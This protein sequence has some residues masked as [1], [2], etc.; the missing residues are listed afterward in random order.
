MNKEA[1][2]A[3][4]RA[5]LS[6]LPENET[7]ERIS[8][9]REMIDDRMADGQTEEEA[10]AGIGSMDEI[11]EQITAEIPLSVI[12]RG[13]ASQRKGMKGWEIALLILGAPLWIPLLIAAIAV[14]L[15][16]YAALWAVV[17]SLWAVDLSLAAA[18]V[19]SLVGMVPYLRAG[20]PA[21]VGVAGGAALICAGLAILMFHVCISL[22]RAVIR[23]M[24]R[25]L[26]GIKTLFMGKGA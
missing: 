1:F 8:F 7:E 22:T 2:L 26:L 6:G 4:L 16:V 19:G 14:L 3:E 10:V 17:I 20:N 13:K 21:G 12:V 15:S 23:L 24:G 9:Y 18:A 11:I 5:R 25:I